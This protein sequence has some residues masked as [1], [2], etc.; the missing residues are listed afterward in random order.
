MPLGCLFSDCHVAALL[1]MTKKVWKA[2]WFPTGLETKGGLLLRN[3]RPYK[4]IEDCLLVG[5]IGGVAP[6][7]FCCSVMHYHREH[8]LID[9][10]EHNL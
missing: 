3:V 8:L 6:Y 5:G 1:A 10:A 2:P 4:K 9:T 7:I